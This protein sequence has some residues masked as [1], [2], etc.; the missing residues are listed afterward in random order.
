MK[1]IIVV[2]ALLVIAGFGCQKFGG[3]SPKVEIPDGWMTYESADYGFSVSYPDNMELRQRPEE[4]QNSTYAGLQGKFFLSLRDIKREEKP[5]TI[6]TFYAFKD[7]SVEE[8]SESLQASDPENITIK[9]ITDVAQGGINTKKMVSTT[10]VGLDKTHYLF[11]NNENLIVIGVIL[12][13]EAIF[14]PVFETIT[15]ASN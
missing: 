8:F 4:V 1:K 7:T 6:A 12:Q 13:E 3:G 2:F 11:T 5:V 10:A 14:A 9:E 15:A